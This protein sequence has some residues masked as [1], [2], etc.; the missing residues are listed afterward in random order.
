L[1]GSHANLVVAGDAR[2]TLMC[3]RVLRTSFFD[4]DAL[5]IVDLSDGEAVIVVAYGMAPRAEEA[6]SHQTLGFFERLLEVA[7]ASNARGWFS[8]KAWED[9]LITTIQL[10]W[11]GAAAG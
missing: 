7:G 8:T 11:E 4:Y 9:E 2:E 5:Q 3:F 1:T 6:A 10:R